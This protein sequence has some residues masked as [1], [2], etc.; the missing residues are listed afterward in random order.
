ME[1]PWVLG[2]ADGFA[3]VHAIVSWVWG[4]GGDFISSDGARA[5]FFE[6]NT[7]DGLEAFFRLMP[8]MPQA[9]LPIGVADAQRWFVE[10]KSAITIGPYGFLREFQAAAPP[11]FR[12]QLGVSM[13]PGPPLIA[14]SDLVLWAHSRNT[15]EMLSLLYSLFNPEIQL[16]YAEYLG[17]LPVTRA[18]LEHLARSTDENIRAFVDILEHGRLFSVSKFS[19]MLEAQLAGVLADVWKD[20]AEHP[21]DDIRSQLQIALE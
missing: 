13:P 1:A 9:G 7:L 10:R 12:D 14:G 4:K 15:D 5:A 18:A 2:M 8:Y 6:K 17:D 21:T 11:A 16:G 19:G 3:I 20:L